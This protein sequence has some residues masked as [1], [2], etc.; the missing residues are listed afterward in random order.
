ML[1]GLG[2]FLYLFVVNPTYITGDFMEPAVKNGSYRFSN[3]LYYKFN[4]YKPGDIIVFS[5]EDKMCFSRVVAL[6]NQEIKISEN[7]IFVNG[8]VRHDSVRRDCNNWKLGTYGIDDVFKIPKG[9][10]YVLSDNLSSQHDDSRVFGPI[11]YTNI[12]GKLW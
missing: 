2:L 12:Y 1:F 6:E 5:Y 10:L 8:E 9:H 7:V 3:Y 11:S 4:A